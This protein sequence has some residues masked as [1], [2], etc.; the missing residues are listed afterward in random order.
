VDQNPSAAQAE[1]DVDDELLEQTSDRDVEGAGDADDSVDETTPSPILDADVVG[2]HFARVMQWI[3]LHPEIPHTAFRVYAILASLCGPDGTVPDL[4]NDQ[5]MY[6]VPGVNGKSM[7]GT[8]LNDALAA[9]EKQGV[10]TRTDDR[11]QAARRLQPP[12]RSTFVYV[13]GGERGLVKIG[14]SEHPERRL[15]QL[16]TGSGMTLRLLWQTEGGIR[17]ERTLHRKFGLQRTT[18]E[19]FDFDQA[20]PVAAVSAAVAELRTTAAER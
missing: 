3:A 18:G 20:D 6:L 1:H 19:W 16:Q 10:L 7:G 17:L 13:I 9:L 12:A 11:S 15:A 2:V 5:L 8:A 4:S 14:V